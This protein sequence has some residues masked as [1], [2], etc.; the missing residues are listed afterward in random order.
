MQISHL[1]QN[2]QMYLHKEGEILSDIIREKGFYSQNDLMVFKSLLSADAVVADVGAN[3][4][5]HSLSMALAFPQGKILAIEPEQRNLKVLNQNIAA[6][7]LQNIQTLPVALSNYQGQGRLT[8][9]GANYGDH[10][11][12]PVNLL[13]QRLDTVVEVTTGDALFASLNLQNLDLIKMDAQGSECKIL[14]GMRE[15]IRNYKPSIMLE[16]SPRHIRAAGDSVFEIFA[17]IEKNNYF[18]FQV[19][20][21]LDRPAN[22]LLDFVTLENLLNANQVLMQRGTGVDI[23]LLQTEKIE[24]LQRKGF[25]L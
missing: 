23:L 20:E 18:P 22:K 5:W 14:D 17:F 4:G 1:D 16:F 10:I 8:L 6:N 24:A 25:Q 13:D 12:D 19:V 15:T 7:N 21:D 3:I 11:L 2:F 9:S